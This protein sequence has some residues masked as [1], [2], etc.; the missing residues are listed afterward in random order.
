MLA[1]AEKRYKL[2]LVGN[3]GVGSVF[4]C[5]GWLAEGIGEADPGFGLALVLGRG[6]VVGRPIFWRT[7]SSVQRRLRGSGRGGK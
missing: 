2:V 7:S 1:A 5:R 3:S 6:G 4:G